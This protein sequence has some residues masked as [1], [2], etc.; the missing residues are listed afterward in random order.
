MCDRC[1]VFYMND[2]LYKNC[3]MSLLKK[4]YLWK[5]SLHASSIV[6]A[7]HLKNLQTLNKMSRHGFTGVFSQRVS[8]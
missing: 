5:T 4:P 2:G 8:R 7:A 1:D 6:Q 3:F